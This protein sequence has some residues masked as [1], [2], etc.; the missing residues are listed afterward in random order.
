MRKCVKI[1]FYDSKAM[2]T[3]V[4]FSIENDSYIGT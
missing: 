2:F 4:K 3:L 1:D